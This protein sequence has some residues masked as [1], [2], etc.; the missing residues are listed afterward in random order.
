MAVEC[1]DGMRAADFIFLDAQG[2]GEV[3]Y[4][5][6]GRKVLKKRKCGY[7]LPQATMAKKYNDASFR[8]YVRHIIGTPESHFTF[9][10][11]HEI[12]QTKILATC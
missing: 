5:N 2:N 7:H 3:S 9:C 4:G 11:L 1:Q 10:E 6:E 8:N 12:L